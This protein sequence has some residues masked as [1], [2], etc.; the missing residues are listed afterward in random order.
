MQEQAYRKTIQECLNQP[1]TYNART[2][3]STKALS[4]IVWI[5]EDI[6]VLTSRKIN[7]KGAVAELLGF[8]NGYT[9]AE[10]FRKLGTKTW[11]MNANNN[12]AWLNNLNRKGTDDMGK[13]YGAVGKD[14]GG[15]NL[16]EKVYNNL[17]QGIDDRGEIITY[18]KPD[19]FHKGCLRPCM[20]TFQFV[21]I[22][23]KLDL[24]VNQRS[25][26]LLLGSAYNMIQAWAF[27]YLM[28]LAT[29]HK[30]GKIT[31]INANA[32]IYE[33]QL[34]AADELL[35]REMTEYTPTM[36]LTPEA[37]SLVQSANSFEEIASSLTVDDFIVKQYHHR[38]PL[39]IPFTV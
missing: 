37:L 15:I 38:E 24:I 19:E 20:H 28:C 17:K 16:F 18:W 5:Y 11:D 2:N 34:E 21:L 10:D 4:S 22:A 14:F 23:G 36:E 7:W 31:H 9:S 29:G 3:S 26:D 35:S 1:L 25:S 33:N 30:Q 13:V 39:K 8:M 27:L 12:T 6:C 32:H